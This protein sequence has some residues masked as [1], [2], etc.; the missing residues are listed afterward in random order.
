MRANKT[1]PLSQTED[2]MRCDALCDCRL[3]PGSQLPLAR[4]T[5]FVRDVRH[6]VSERAQYMVMI[7]GRCKSDDV[8]QNAR[9][10]ARTAGRT[11]WVAGLRV[12]V[13]MC[14]R[15]GEVRWCQ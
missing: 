7:L 15:V 12:R 13:A 4:D 10:V 5:F 2:A 9:H 11:G 1:L 8:A 6:A 14:C 3:Y